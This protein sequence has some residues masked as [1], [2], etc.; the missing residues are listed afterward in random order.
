M[1]RAQL[2]KVDGFTVGRENVGYVS[3][4]VPVDLTNIKLDDLFDGI[5]NLQTRAATVY[6]DPSK[7]PPMGKGLNVPATISLE[8]SWPRV[9]GQ[10]SAA[11]PKRLAKHIERLKRIENTT[12]ESY[13]RDAGIWTF[14]VEHFTTYGLDY[15]DDETDAERHITDDE[16]A[17]TRR[18]TADDDDTLEVSHPR[19]VPK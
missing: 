14:S 11:D 6:P 4:K 19:Q 16:D 2:Q 12:F 17:L 8:Q 15:D 9:R 7:K 3:F 1:T 13:D 10:K 5:V 18:K